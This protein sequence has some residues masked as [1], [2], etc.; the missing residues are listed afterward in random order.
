MKKIIAAILAFCLM[1]M[2]LPAMADGLGDLLTMLGGSG[3][4]AGEEN[5][6]VDLSGLAGMFGGSEGGADLSGLANMFGGSGD[7]LGDMNLDS[8]ASLFSGTGG[9]EGQ[10]VDLGAIL[11]M[12][13][14][15][16]AT[17]V[18]TVAASSPEQFYGTWTIQKISA[19]GIEIGLDFLKQFGM[20]TIPAVTLT[21]DSVIA[22]TDD[23][24]K[25]TRAVTASDF[26]DGVLTITVDN[27]PAKLQLTAEGNVLCSISGEAVGMDMMLDILFVPAP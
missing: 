10:E 7:A 27:T 19:A 14:V 11:G 3:D 4:S 26:T 17:A 24:N 23:G 9:E 25:E 15:G 6:S 8:L 2:V 5:G 13:G 12:F 22:D 1:M 18:N 20:E 21:A 16:E